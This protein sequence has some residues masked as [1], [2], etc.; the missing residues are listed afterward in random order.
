VFARFLVGDG[1]HLTCDVI[2]QNQKIVFE[3]GVHR[4]ALKVCRQVITR[5]LLRADDPAEARIAT[6]ALRSFLS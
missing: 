2:E 4:P 1:A 5:R 6:A 3:I